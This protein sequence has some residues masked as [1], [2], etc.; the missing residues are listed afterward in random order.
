MFGNEE[1]RLSCKGARPFRI[2][3][4]YL[5]IND[6]DKEH[7]PPFQNVVPLKSID[8][9]KGL[10]YRYKFMQIPIV[11]T[12]SFMN[13]PHMFRGFAFA[14]SHLCTY[15]FIDVRGFVWN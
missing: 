10:N 3:I 14:S 11:D 4:T 5:T 9:F 15:V 7:T 8:A 13:K 2:S 6:C 12:S 1:S